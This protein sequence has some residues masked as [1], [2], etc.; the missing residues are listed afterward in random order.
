MCSSDLGKDTLAILLGEKRSLRL[1]KRILIIL[2]AALLGLSALHLISYLGFL[3]ISCP[4]W[5]L[6]LISAYER[7]ILLPS[8]KLE[9]LVESN[10]ILAGVFAFLWSLLGY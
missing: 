7:G 1:L 9:L 8:V 3:L 2:M 5:L 10:F 6:F 4:V